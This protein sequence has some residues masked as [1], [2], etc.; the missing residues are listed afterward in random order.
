MVIGG[1]NNELVKD[2]EKTAELLHNPF[3]SVYYWA[4]GQISDIKAMRDALASR[5]NVLNVTSKI[6]QKR[7]NVKKEYANNAHGRTTLKTFFKS[8][9]EKQQFQ[10]QLLKQIKMLENTESSYIKLTY[11]LNTILL[12]SVAAFKR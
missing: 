8:S 4:K 11:I 7:Q 10:S 9:N 6:N 3:S 2:F 1:Q 12:K 5:E